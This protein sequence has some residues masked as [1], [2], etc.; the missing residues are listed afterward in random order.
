MHLNIT[1]ETIVTWENQD[2]FGHTIQSQDGVGNVI[3]IFNSNILFTGQTFDYKFRE[4]GDYQYF[5]TLHP[6]RVGTISVI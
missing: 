6:W 4:I 3:P 1:K 5:C 2:D